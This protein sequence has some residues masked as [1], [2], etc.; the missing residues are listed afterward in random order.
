MGFQGCYKIF[1]GISMS[2][3]DFYGIS[4]KIIGFLLGFQGFHRIFEGFQW[5]LHRTIG[6]SLYI[7]M[8]IGFSW[9]GC[10]GRNGMMKLVGIHNQPASF[11][12]S[13]L[14]SLFFWTVIHPSSCDPRD[15][16]R[17]VNNDQTSLF[18]DHIQTLL[19][20]LVIH[21]S[22]CLICWS[23]WFF[24]SYFSGLYTII[25]LTILFFYFHPVV[26]GFFHSQSCFK[27][28]SNKCRKIDQTCTKYMW[29]SP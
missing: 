21:P 4:K 24:S 28:K 15:D 18:C 22:S 14:T 9:E 11:V 25:L 5:W 8:M 19:I 17:D 23:A 12:W 16:P 10:T 20:I 26:P 27:E 6:I 3:Q 2:S 13:W 7:S 1:T 29:Q